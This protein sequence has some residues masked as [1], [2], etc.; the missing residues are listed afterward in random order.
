MLSTRKD[1]L[2]DEVADA[3]AILQDRATPMKAEEVRIIVHRVFGDRFEHVFAVFDEDPVASATIAQVHRAVLRR[4]GREVAVKIKRPGIERR[5]ATD[6]ALLQLAA[7]AVSR[8]W[9]FRF[10]PLRDG[11]QLI[12]AALLQQCDFPR[13]ARN[14][15]LC[16]ALLS[17]HQDVLVPDVI[18]E[19]CGEEILVMEFMPYLRRIESGA[20]DQRRA[21]LAGLRA[22]YRMIFCGGTVH[23]DLHPGNLLMSASGEAAMLD[24]GFTASI[25]AAER[26]SFAEFFLSITAG[27]GVTAAAVVRKAAAALPLT[28]DGEAFERDIRKLVEAAAR[29]SAHQFSVARFVGALF[30]IQARHQIR[31]SP[32]FTMAIVAL[33]V[34]EGLLRQ[35]CPDVDFQREAIPFVL[36]AL[37]TDQ[38]DGK[39][40]L[41]PSD[42][43][44]PGDPLRIVG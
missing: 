32:T 11:L 41:T 19:L 1:L 30:A 33:V 17:E 13:E 18:G 12:C 29:Q 43:P 44:E 7:R 6:L 15:R 35:T 21:V 14:Q 4:S 36:Q 22:L 40:A 3:L 24:F 20:G 38:T 26:I 16:R 5:I 31:G 25:T 23:C 28:L 10:L 9:V 37:A 2:P 27:D 39:V 42:L 8:V 34:F